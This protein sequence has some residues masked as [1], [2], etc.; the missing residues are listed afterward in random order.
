MIDTQNLIKKE[1][2]GM[3]DLDLYDYFVSKAISSENKNIRS[4]K[5]KIEGCVSGLWVEAK[6]INNCV[7]VSTDS[8][9]LVIKGIS[10][11]IC[12]IFNGMS[13][14]QVKETEIDFLNG[15][16]LSGELDE[17]RRTGLAKIKDRVLFLNKL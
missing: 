7:S 1:I 15:T 11:C 6:L 14:E 2:S 10:L 12:D 13:L 16:D 17:R 5:N 9:S 3:D 8:D 4:E